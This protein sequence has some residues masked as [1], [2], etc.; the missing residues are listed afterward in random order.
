M[1]LRTDMIRYDS[2]VSNNG[3][4]L[5]EIAEAARRCLQD[6]PYRVLRRISCECKNGILFLRGNLSSFHEKQAA[7]EAVARVKGM[8]QVVNEIDVD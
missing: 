3:I 4:V 8:I 7:Q 1:S 5:C 6:S 2:M